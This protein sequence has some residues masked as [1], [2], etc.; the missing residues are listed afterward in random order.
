MTERAPPFPSRLGKLK[1][2]DGGGGLN[3]AQLVVCRERRV[4]VGRM[5]YYIMFIV[6]RGDV[7]GMKTGGGGVQLFSKFHFCHVSL[8]KNKLGGRGR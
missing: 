3:V 8:L 2:S 5:F 1:V 4:G 6:R 7:K